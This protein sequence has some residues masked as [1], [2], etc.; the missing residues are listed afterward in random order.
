MATCIV[1]AIYLFLGL[2]L[3]SL[4]RK[5]GVWF[6]VKDFGGVPEF[7]ASPCCYVMNVVCNFYLI[8]STE[9]LNSTSLIGP[10]PTKR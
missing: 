10:L 7:G 9:P 4:D 2:F 3:C 5:G 1:S 6:V 8:I